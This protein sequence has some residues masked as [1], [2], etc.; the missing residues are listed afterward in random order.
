MNRKETRQLVLQ[1]Q[2]L[3]DLLTL[4][5][6]RLGEGELEFY[7]CIA[8]GSSPERHFCSICGYWGIYTCVD[9][10]MR[11]CSLMCKSAHTDTRCLK[12]VS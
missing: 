11:Y 10:G 4:E 8:K 12:H 6:Q 5:M 1:K 7:S 3:A 2:S 9:C